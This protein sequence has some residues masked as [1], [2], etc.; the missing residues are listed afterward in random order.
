MNCTCTISA[1]PGAI[2]PFLLFFIVNEVS[3]GGSML[4]LCGIGDLFIILMLNV[5][6]LLS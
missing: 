6:A 3:V 4:I 1:I 5:C 2:D